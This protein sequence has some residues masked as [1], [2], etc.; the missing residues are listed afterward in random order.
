MTASL[1]SL[2]RLAQV[3]GLALRDLR[4]GWTT[5]LCLSVAVTAALLPL[6]I[7]F[8]LK[9]GVVN[10]LIETLRS[11]PGV[12]EIRLVRETQLSLDWF[13]RLEARGDVAFLLPRGNFLAAS[14]RLRGTDGRALLETRMLPTAPRDP[15]L[16][17][18]ATPK[19][20]TEI[21]MT[22]RVALEAKAKPGDEVELI[23]QRTVDNKR[24][25]V[26]LKVRVVGVVP[27]DRLQTDDIL[28]AP[29]LETSVETW[30]QGFAV[31]ELGWVADD[32]GLTQ[33]RPER[34]AY[35]SFR[36]YVNDVRD[37]PIVRDV[38]LQDGLD[39]R[40]RAEEVLRVLVIERALTLIFLAITTLGAVGFVLTL[41]LHL[42]AKVVDQAR[43][44]AILRL[45][46]LSSAELSLLPSV[47][48]MAIACIGSAIACL[49]ALVGQPAINDG[50][51]RSRRDGRRS[52]AVGT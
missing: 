51:W 7:L 41:G 29:A 47:Q 44:L 21:V 8:G 9:F 10:N 36:L 19:E 52:F 6:L 50:F 23:I 42:A 37:V 12:R 40:T 39:V 22:T 33:L 18:L 14:V 28:V 45:L 24:Q 49:L 4:H 11:D 38:L 3:A 16:E 48:G 46:G 2:P 34:T 5:T 43:E 27:R 17:G 15:L 1:Q 26:R 20:T 25:A 35:S 30:R 31:P 13:A 32:G